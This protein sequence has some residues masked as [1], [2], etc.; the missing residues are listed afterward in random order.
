M[1]S[2]QWQLGILVTISAFF[3]GTGKPRKPCVE[4]AEKSVSRQ[5]QFSK[6]M[7]LQVDIFLNIFFSYIS[8]VYLLRSERPVLISSS[9]CVCLSTS[10]LVANAN[11]T[12]RTFYIQLSSITCFGRFGRHQLDTTATCLKRKNV[13]RCLEQL[14]LL[15]TQQVIRTKYVDE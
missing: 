1:R 15:R 12:I 14:S 4:V 7:P 9:H 2:M 8:F 10:L 5:F 11:K 3:L 13:E 6:F